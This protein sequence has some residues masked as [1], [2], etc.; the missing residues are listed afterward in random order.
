[1]ETS[2]TLSISRDP[3]DLWAVRALRHRVFVEEMGATPG[4]DG[5]EGDEF[6][7]GCDHLI[8]RDRAR[9][10]L[11]VVATLRTR[12]GAAYT[13][14]E[15]DVAALQAT[16]RKMAELGR[17]CLHRDYRGGLAGLII[18][19]GLLDILHANGVG[20]VVGTASFPGADVT[21]HLP[22][23]RRLRAEALAPPHLCPVARGAGAVP[24]SG[25]APRTAMTG[26]P[27]LIKTYLRAGA[28]VGDGAYI[29][30]NFNT[31]DI[32]M[33]LDLD[34]VAPLGRQA[35]RRITTKGADTNV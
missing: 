17:A 6:D 26:V 30:R 21:P 10:D 14:R 22:A 24:I 11:G 9:P 3:A 31:V 12:P 34:R 16:G 28:W 4:P 25:D 33:V 27:A 29:D 32:C 13:A 8:L 35:G 15:F 1:M 7:A 19:K 18:F 5:Q 2:L 23:L 20:L